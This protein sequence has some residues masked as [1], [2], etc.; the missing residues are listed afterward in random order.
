MPLAAHTEEE[1]DA[2]LGQVAEATEGFSGAELEGLC[3]YVLSAIDPSLPPSLLQ[4]KSCHHS[5]FVNQLIP[6]LFRSDFFSIREAALACL[7]EEEDEYEKESAAGRGKEEPEK[8]RTGR[9]GL[10]HFEAAMRGRREEE[11]G[12]E[13]ARG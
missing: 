11:E 9:I 6:F 13:V 10:R 12:N 7:R 1:E 5:S 3:R 4:L 8:E 2:L